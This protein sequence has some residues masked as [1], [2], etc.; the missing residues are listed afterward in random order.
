MQTLEDRSH[1]QNQYLQN[2]RQ[3]RLAAMGEMAAKI[4]HEVRNPLGSIELFATSLRESL[5]GQEELQE[6]AK[7]I[8]MGVKNINSIVSNLLLFI[9]PDEIKT[10]QPFDV[11]EALE[12]SLFFTSH[13]TGRSR[14]IEVRKV[15][16]PGP[17]CIHGDIELIKQMCLNLI[18]N[19]I[20]GMPEGGRLVIT[21]RR[22]TFRELDPPDW[23]ELRFSDTGIGIA[24]EHLSKIF[25]PFFTT[26]QSGTGLGL[27]IVH[28]IV[29]V[30]QGTLDA[31]STLGQ[32]TVFTVW[33]PLCPAA[34]PVPPAHLE[35]PLK[36][37]G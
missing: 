28:S 15:V 12:D 20:Q 19:A 4:A 22:R 16:G 26:K 21:A 34:E 31:A 29:D 10:F 8:S 23:V 9:K 27:S 2:H 11:C 5:D 14:G 33:L 1:I 3:E 36:G 13:L 6:L 25:D 32:G 37:I 7:R 24:P 18:L 35:P 30:H 17:L